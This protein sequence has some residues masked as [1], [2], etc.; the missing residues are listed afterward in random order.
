LIAGVINEG[1]VIERS[2]GENE[3]APG[4]STNIGIAERI[5]MENDGLN[6]AAVADRLLP[7]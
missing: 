3:S 5:G 6:D 4:G 2:I 7:F 1:A